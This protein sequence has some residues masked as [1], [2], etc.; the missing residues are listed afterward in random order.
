MLYGP[1]LLP[2][3]LRAALL[4]EQPLVLE[5]GLTGS[6][7]DRHYRPDGA[8]ARY[9]RGPAS[10][11]VAITPV[12]FVVWAGRMKQV[13]VPHNHALRRTVKVA[14]DGRDRVLFDVDPRLADPTRTKRVEVRLRTPS[15]AYIVQLLNAAT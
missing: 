2:D 13:D 14:L 8:R 1:G 11:A 4:A 6:V 9:E 3:D 12:R 5:E 7:T 10:G 15:A